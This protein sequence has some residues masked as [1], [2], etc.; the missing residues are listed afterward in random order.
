MDYN[1]G[2]FALLP[3]ALTITAPIFIL[4]SLGAWL[5]HIKFINDAFI[6]VSSKFIFNIG[7]PVIL[8]FT[9]SLV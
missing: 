8:L 7:L 2:I 6:H 3:A 9:F 5:C 4:I 1:Q